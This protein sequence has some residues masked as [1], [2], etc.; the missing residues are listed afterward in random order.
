M[1]SL[2]TSVL[3]KQSDLMKE[4]QALRRENEQLRQLL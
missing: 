1:G 4:V 3:E 2:M